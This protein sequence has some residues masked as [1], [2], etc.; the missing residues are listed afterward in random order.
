MCYS[1]SENVLLLDDSTS[2]LKSMPSLHEVIQKKAI[3]FWE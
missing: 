1:Y 3:G 2:G